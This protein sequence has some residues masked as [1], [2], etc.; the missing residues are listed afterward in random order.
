MTA[1]ESDDKM[2]VRGESGAAGHTLTAVIQHQTIALDLMG[3]V[4]VARCNA[5]VITNLYK[6]QFTGY[7]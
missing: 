7:H 1:T 2:L 5:V 4:V 6:V 3:V